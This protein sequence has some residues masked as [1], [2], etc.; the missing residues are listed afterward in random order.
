M[1]WFLNKYV[2]ESCGRLWTDEWSCAC[3]DDCPH[4]GARHM[5]PFDSHDLSEVIV[6]A[7]GGY[8]V[9]RSADDAEDDPE[10]VTV[11]R[12]ATKV[13]AE[14]FAKAQPASE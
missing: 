8:A 3:N 9:L 2:C 10:Y 14:A 13:E 11:A 4:C 1:T 6:P 5:E 7:A 12:F